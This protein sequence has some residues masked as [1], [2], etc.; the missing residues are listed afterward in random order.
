M[1]KLSTLNWQGMP[2]QIHDPETYPRKV[3]A[4]VL[5]S[6]GRTYGP[7]GEDPYLV[8]AFTDL[9]SECTVIGDRYMGFSSIGFYELKAYKPYIEEWVAA[10]PDDASSM[11]DVIVLNG[12]HDWF[13]GGGSYFQETVSMT[14]SDIKVLFPEARIYSSYVGWGGFPEADFSNVYTA[15]I[16]QIAGVLDAGCKWIPLEALSHA[17]T[18]PNDPNGDY[19]A[20]PDTTSVTLKGMERFSKALADYIVNGIIPE[21]TEVMQAAFTGWLGTTSDTF[22][23]FVD[24]KQMITHMYTNQ[25]THFVFTTPRALLCDGSMIKIAYG[26]QYKNCYVY[27]HQGVTGYAG[28]ELSGSVL[29]IIYTTDNDVVS[30]PARIYIYQGD[31]YIMLNES[32]SGTAK[33]YTATDLYIGPFEITCDTM[34]N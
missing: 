11:T 22:N 13:G 15:Y 20:V 10:H 1:N 21:K 29:A 28:K 17:S 3:K 6:D 8:S 25:V 31:T 19:N 18:D 16:S 32:A 27:G 12:S 9:G 5:G 7:V 30:L 33:T 26:T 4:L 34:M 23:S 2:I 24:L 14:M